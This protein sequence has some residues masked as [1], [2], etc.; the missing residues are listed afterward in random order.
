MNL[1]LGDT[2]DIIQECKKR[3]LLRNQAAYV[4]ATTYW[5][6]GRTMRPVT[7]M[8][9]VQYLKSKKYYPYIG[10]GY[11]QLTWEKNYRDWSKRLNIDLVKYPAKAQ[12]PNV[13]R[14]ILVEGMQLGTFTGKKLS[15]YIT[16][17]KSDF[18]NARRIVN[19]MD[20]ASFIADLAVAYDKSLK[21]AGYGVESS[22]LP[23]NPQSSPAG[24]SGLFKA[25]L[26]WL[27]KF[28]ES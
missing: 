22:T 18:L 28:S 21:E 14:C 3:G 12:D 11:V 10:R 16:L 8:G 7:E 13:A 24:F 25:I 9:S 27:K 2:R 5:E 4:L 17:K 19:G 23:E 6:T 20:K 1:D 15:D 26:A